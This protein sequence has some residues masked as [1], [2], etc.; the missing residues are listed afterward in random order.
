MSRPYHA[1]EFLHA[2]NWTVTESIQALERRDPTKPFFL[3]MSFARPHS[4]YDPP[5]FYF[6]LYSGK[7]LPSA[8]VGEWAD[9]HDVHADAVNPNAWRGRRSAE[10][11]RRARAGYY[12]L[13]HHIDHQIGRMMRWLTEQRL[14]SNTMIVFVSDHGDMLG[15]HHLWRKT[16][17]YEGSAHIPFLVSL[18]QSMQPAKQ[19][20]IEEPVCLQDVM[21]TILDACGVA[22]PGS[23]D[24]SSVLPLIRGEAVQ[25][26]PYVHGEHCASYAADEE[27]QYLTDGK[28]KYIWF[29]RK[30]SEQLFHLQEDRYECKDLAARTEFREQLELWRGRLIGE[31][32][33]RQAGLTDEGRLVSQ[34]G[35]PPLI[36]PKYAERL[37]R[38]RRRK[39]G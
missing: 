27:M 3:K 5:P 23:V 8:Q 37:E 33:S 22:I 32:A 17:A 14:L 6:D 18:P 7:E 34:K 16:Y 30:D 38:V 39:G 15:D 11:I 24:G 19:K 20:E 25:W 36:S 26:R 1:P 12:G 31:L 29:P 9:V 13:I 35:Q 2:T 21:P 10:E 28:W 4:P